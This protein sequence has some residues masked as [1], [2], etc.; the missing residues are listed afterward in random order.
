MS[1]FPIPGP[2]S[3]GDLLDRSFRLY[4][5]RF[6]IFVATAALF[7]V[8]LSVVSGLLTGTFV[9]DYLDALTALGTGGQ[10]PSEDAVFRAFG[11]ALSFASAMFILG[12]IAL[13]LNGIVTLALTNQSIAALN[14]ESLTI[15]Q[16]VGRAMRRFWP[17]LRMS[18][19]Q[20]LAFF[21]STV[22]ILVV[23][24]ILVFLV[25]AVGVAIG[26]SVDSLGDTAGIVA[27]VGLGLILVC[28][29][30]LALIL[31]LLPVVYLSARWVV[32]V[33]ALVNEEWGARETLRRSWALTAG[34]VWRAVGYVILLWLIGTLVIYLP[35]GVFQQILL[36][37]LSFAAP[38]MAT[39]ISTALGSLFSVLWVPFNAGALVL[40]YYDLRVRKESYDLEM[41]IDRMAA[42][43]EEKRN[44]DEQ[45]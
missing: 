36:I 7:L 35:V 23:L 16:G 14:G 37:L 11:G 9:T 33:P 32:A 38:G 13:V 8:P 30:I 3:L 1:T 43:V 41:R 4:R 24:G 6:G 45:A 22:A 18:I 2:L 20:G 26:L 44:V 27:A 31:L 19:L 17:L 29:Y 28:G 5:A 25:V 15:G 12:I 40:L 21:F 42:E 39:M 10:A 34:G